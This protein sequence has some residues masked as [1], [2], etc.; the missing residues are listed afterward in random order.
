[1]A[2]PPEGR[3]R[4]YWPAAEPPDDRIAATQVIPTRSA[5][6]ITM[7]P[8][9]SEDQMSLREKA[10]A[11]FGELGTRYELEKVQ[12]AIANLEDIA[13]TSPV[14]PVYAADIND[15]PTCGRDD[16]I[17]WVASSHNHGAG[18]YSANTS[19]GNVTGTSGSATVALSPVPASYKPSTPFSLGSSHAP[20]D[21]T[22]IVVDRRG[23]VKRLRWRVGT[24]A[25][26]FSIAAYYMALCV[27]NPATQNIE[28]VWDSGNIKDGVA[29]TN[30]LT[31]VGIDM[32]IDQV[33]VPGQILFVAHQQIATGLVQEGR[34]YACKPQTGSAARPGQLLNAWYYRTP[35]N[36]GS[37][38]SSVSFA[39]LDRRNDCIPW[40]A[41]SVDSTVSE[42][43]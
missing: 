7:P 10:N 3:D 11:I 15:M 12:E 31:E 5:P 36:V 16:L 2:P 4:H 43:A 6:K 13:P 30:S 8:P 1:M 26:I 42:A 35:D 38:P 17:R 34:T 14:T 20:V 18:G 25:N 22:P 27:Y 29:N 21:Y 33:C 37:I 9:Q 39:S 41:V 40:A 28:K 23:V 24:D 19:T 32:G